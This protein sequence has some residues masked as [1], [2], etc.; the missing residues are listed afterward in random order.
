MYNPDEDGITHINVYSKGKTEL[1]RFLTNFAWAPFECPDGKF[2]TIEGYWYW[3]STGDDHLRTTNGWESK[4][5]GRKIRG[6]DWVED[7]EFKNKILNAIGIKISYGRYLLQFTKSTLPF[8]HYYNYSGK[9]I[10]PKEGKW[11]MEFL[12]QLRKDLTNQ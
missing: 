1:G 10:E 8:V 4:V 3:L 6:K 12:E 5:Y 11:I 7:P 9:I 2:K